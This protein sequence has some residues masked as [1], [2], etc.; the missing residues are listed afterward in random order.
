MSDKELWKETSHA[1]RINELRNLIRFL[2]E[3]GVYNEAV[4]SRETF[5]NALTIADEQKELET[6]LIPL[7]KI[8]KEIK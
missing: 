6:S 8:P 7:W 2:V 5:K 1:K 3:Y 4:R